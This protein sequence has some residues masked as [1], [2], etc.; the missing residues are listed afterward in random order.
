MAMKTDDHLADLCDQ[1]RAGDSQAAFA[2]WDRCYEP[3]VRVA[4]QKLNGVPRRAFDEEDVA[5]SALHVFMEGVQ[6]GRFHPRRDGRGLWQL[7]LTITTRKAL[8][9]RRREMQQKRGGGE[10][11]GDSVFL[12]RDGDNSAFCGLQ[13]QLT[14]DDSPDQLDVLEQAEQLVDALP[15]ES[16]RRIA[17][18]RLAGYTNE[19]IARTLGCVRRTVERKL[20]RI[21]SRWAEH[22]SC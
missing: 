20:E 16:H 8:L 4:R 21:R 1:L 22:V 6:A 2:L 15:D 17:R 12:R 10:V 19:E 14:V 7:L 3:V 13:Q 9:Y 11:R 18:L 5:L